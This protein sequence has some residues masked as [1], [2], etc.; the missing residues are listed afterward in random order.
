MRQTKVDAADIALVLEGRSVPI[1]GVAPVTTP[2][3]VPTQHAP[4]SLLSAAQS[5]LVF[6]VPIPQ[7]VV[8]ADNHGL[9]LYWRFCNITY[10][11]LDETANQLCLL[12]EERGYPSAPVYG[13]YPWK[14]VNRTYYGLAS[15]IYAAE[16]A[17]LGRLTRAG[18]LAH[19]DHGTRLLLAGVVTTLDLPAAVPL[20]WDPCP[21]E[22]VACVDACPAHAIDAVGHVDHERC[23][24]HAHKNPAMWHFLQDP[25]TRAKFDLE[26][27]LNTVGVDDHATYECNACIAFCPLSGSVS[28]ADRD[29]A[30]A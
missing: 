29:M 26:T 27:H 21:K 12:L 30:L 28:T 17:G 9:P 14:S 7:G 8:H 13:C 4:T 3:K 1:F 24:R 25:A 18:L 16:A 22:C 15:L 10:R 2:A 19:P 23:A 6:G 5:M 11:T 20:D